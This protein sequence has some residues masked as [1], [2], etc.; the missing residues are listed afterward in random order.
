MA[1]LNP[2]QKTAI[3]HIDS[4][5]LVLAGAGSGKTLT[6]THKIQ[7]L[8][9]EYGL[10]PE[11]ICAVTFTN[12]AAREMRQ[13]IGKLLGETPRG[14][15]IS[16]FHSLGLEIIR[17]QH[18]QL[19][20]K[21]SFSILDSE[22]SA[23]LVRDLMRA[24]LSQEKGVAEQ[25]RWC[26]SNWK[27]G[28]QTPEEIV[29][30]TFTQPVE[31]AAARVYPEYQRHLKAYNAVD[32]DDLIYIPTLLFRSTPET[33]A[34]WQERIRYL[35]VDEYQDTNGAQYELVKLLVGSRHGLTVVGDDDQSIYAWRGAQPENLSQL[36]TDFPG[37]KVVKLEQNYRS[38][39]RILKIANTLIGNNPHDFNKA[40]WSDLGYGEPVRVMQSN[41]EE[42]EADRVVSDIQHQ[43]FQK[44]KKYS[45]FAILYRSNH[46]SRPFER[47]L[48]ER[49]LPYHLSGGTSFFDRT[50]I[51]DL[52]AYFRLV[53]NIDDDTA[54]LRAVDTPRRH[55]GPATLEKL[56]SYA[57]RRGTSLLAAA[58]ELGLETVLNATQLTRL[59]RFTD[60][61]MELSQSVEG[62]PAVELVQ[63]IISES[64]YRDWLR[65]L[66]KDEKAVARRLENV[67]ELLSWIARLAKT[68][69]MEKTLHDVI[70][71]LTLLG[72]L[73]KDD[74]DDSNNRISLMTLHAAK[75]LEFP[76]VVIA[77]MEENIL[78][79]HANQE[80]AGLEEERRLAYVGITRARERLVFSMTRKRKRHGEMMHCEPSRF[81]QELPQDDLSWDNKAQSTQEEKM[82]LGNAYLANLRSLVE[83][84]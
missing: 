27:N 79:H 31:L 76:C 6:I 29:R 81:L 68:E 43:I 73:E 14:L 71:N 32:F 36:K 23:A 18:T 15:R 26:I 75:G 1:N 9:K 40:L 77:G 58:Q 20:Y 33:L 19:G 84:G 45:D 35:L 24:E 61:I 78:P 3:R 7:W 5:L 50:E 17:R 11:T 44:R 22:D 42:Q 70:A 51:K 46:L 74:T 82:E 62:C 39:Q 66:Y 54:F 34:G 10:A 16:T 2:E 83:E 25:V 59:R 21:S 57:S 13:R 12:K 63:R 65:E 60:W 69:H 53:S 30:Q 37:L 67:D 72:M 64:D 38:M 48:R 49:N 52:M 80:G 28:L 8:I 56:G 4:P 55:I 47:M 41:S